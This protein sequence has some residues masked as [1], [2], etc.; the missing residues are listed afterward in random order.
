MAKTKNTSTSCKHPSNKDI[1][2]PVHFLSHQSED[3][4][5]YLV[6]SWW[7]FPKEAYGI[8]HTLIM[9]LDN[10]HTVT[11]HFVEELCFL[12]SLLLTR[13]LLDRAPV[14]DRRR[15]LRTPDTS[16]DSGKIPSNNA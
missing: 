1:S 9:T 2:P 8:I 16:P 13:N 3:Q 7:N 6:S 4:L 12:R 11:K 10:S 5:L 14:R 15:H